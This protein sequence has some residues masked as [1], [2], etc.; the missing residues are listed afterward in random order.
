MKR[1]TIAAVIILTAAVIGLFAALSAYAGNRRTEEK[2][3]ITDAVYPPREEAAAAP[4]KIDRLSAVVER[5]EITPAPTPEPTPE[6]VPETPDP[7]EQEAD[8]SDQ[9]RATG[10]TW[11]QDE[12]EM[13]AK[14]VWGE[15]R[16]CSTV[17]KA[18]VVWCILNRVESPRFGDSIGAVVTAPSQFFGY[19][20]GNPVDED[21]LAL[22]T[23]V[24]ER[25]A[26]EPAAVGDVGRILPKEYLYFSG[27][28]FYNTYT[29]VYTG[30]AYWDWSAP[31]PYEG[32]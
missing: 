23:D 30:G 3:P 27:N 26:M 29:T 6:P 24:L 28:G 31:N 8:D 17:Q 5:P 20:A 19:S 1:K 18:A 14:T 4:V 21:I 2:P 16:G 32:G 15:A 11:T 7:I 10:R 25:W 12:A 22:V 9:E 13:L